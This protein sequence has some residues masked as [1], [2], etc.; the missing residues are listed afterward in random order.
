MRRTSGFVVVIAGT[1]DPLIYVR[2]NFSINFRSTTDEGTLK[3]HRCCC[4]GCVSDGAL[5]E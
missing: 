2:L 5:C 3:L 1:D 4:L